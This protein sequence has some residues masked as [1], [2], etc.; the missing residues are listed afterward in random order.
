MIIDHTV[1]PFGIVKRFKIPYESVDGRKVH[2]EGQ[3][4]GITEEGYTECNWFEFRVVY[5][6]H[7][8][9]EIGGI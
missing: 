4:R 8:S 2:L 5:P 6:R 7:G 9:K 1:N 3:I